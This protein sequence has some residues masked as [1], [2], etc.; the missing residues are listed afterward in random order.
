MK[1]ILVTGATG[2]IGNHVIQKLIELNERNDLEIIAS[3]ADASKAEHFPWIKQVAYLPFDLRQID[4]AKNYFDYFRQPHIV[5]HLA[6]EGLPNYKDSFH[7][8]TNLPRHFSFLQNLI[9]NGLKDLTVSGTCLE[10]G[11]Q[12]GCLK[13]SQPATPIVSYAVAKDELRKSLEKLNYSHDFSFKW[14][15]LFYVYGKGQNPKS[16]FSQL[17]RAVANREK[18]F[19]M[20]GGDQVR[21]YLPVEKLAAYIVKI[22]FQK[23]ITGI[24]NCCSGKPVAIKHLVEDYL[25]KKNASIKL[26]LGAYPYPDYEPMKFWGDDGK[27]KTALDNE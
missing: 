21:D 5:I 24:I 3:S 6:W 20:S 12:E 25:K 2:F 23:K 10:Y 8:E 9:E 1:R 27:L 15:R 18:V 16:L 11:M 17:D 26:N 14:V 13:E 22:A 4:N 7:L 19:D